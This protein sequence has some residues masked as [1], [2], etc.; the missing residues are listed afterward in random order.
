MLTEKTNSM[1]FLYRFVTLYYWHTY[2]GFT[3]RLVSTSATYAFVSVVYVS[4]EKICN[5]QLVKH[6]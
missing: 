3:N 5:T 2:V 6:K 4:P 1:S